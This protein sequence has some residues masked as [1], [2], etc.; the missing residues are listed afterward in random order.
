MCVICKQGNDS[1]KAVK[2][3]QETFNTNLEG[4]LQSRC[5]V[6][7]VSIA[8]Q[9]V[10]HDTVP[11]SNSRTV[12]FRD[13]KGGLLAWTRQID[14]S[15]PRYWNIK[16]QQSLFW[17][18]NPIINMTLRW[19]IVLVYTVPNQWIASNNNMN[20]IWSRLGWKGDYASILFCKPVGYHRILRVWVV[21]H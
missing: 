19:I 13:V 18:M 9:S 3:L 21:N 4:K 20:F 1:Q 16:R 8:K 17:V 7:S 2:L 10:S 5:P 12:S 15:F 14:S 11:H 6:E